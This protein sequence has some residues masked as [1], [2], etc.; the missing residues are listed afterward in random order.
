MDFIHLWFEPP[1]RYLE[2]Q[3]LTSMWYFSFDY[4]CS[5]CHACISWGRS[6]FG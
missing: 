3:S 1:Q 5:V 6:I 2:N 4:Y